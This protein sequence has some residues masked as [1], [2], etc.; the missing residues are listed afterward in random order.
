MSADGARRYGQP[1]SSVR[2]APL[3][4]APNGAST[5]RRGALRA[6]EASGGL[7]L[8]LRY[9][10]AHPAPIAELSARL[11]TPHRAAQRGATA[12]LL[13]PFGA[14]LQLDLALGA[15]DLGDADLDRVTEAER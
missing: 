3:L 14:Q 15:P 6:G 11:R 13:G 10:P 9:Q 1:V 4:Q 7:R 8:P 2:L 5:R 12:Q